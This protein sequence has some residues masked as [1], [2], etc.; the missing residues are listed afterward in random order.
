MDIY[1]NFDTKQYDSG[2]T[3]GDYTPY[4]P[5]IDAARNMYR[6]LIELG[7]IPLVACAYTLESVAGVAHTVKAK[8][9]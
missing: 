5:T 2:P 6:I 9:E 8:V 3:N 7:N 1:Y 4:I